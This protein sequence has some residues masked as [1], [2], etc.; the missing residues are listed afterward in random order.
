M[1]TKAVE[2]ENIKER[3]ELRI[4]FDYFCS[5]LSFRDSLMDN[6]AIQFM[7]NFNDLVK[8]KVNSARADE[9]EKIKKLM[10]YSKHYGEKVLFE[11]DL[12]KGE[13]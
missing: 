12:K 11:D 13:E 5:R 3:N 7:N 8:K 4:E 9:R 6:R 10:H 2:E 1:K